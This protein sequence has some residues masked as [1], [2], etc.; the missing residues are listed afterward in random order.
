MTI[1]IS[2]FFHLQPKEKKYGTRHSKT[3]LLKR[4]R[5]FLLGGKR[6]CSI[7]GV[8]NKARYSAKGT[9][10]IFKTGPIRFPVFVDL[11]IWL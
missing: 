3:P 1:A 5:G 7:M 9:V 2:V 11:V 8:L 4:D 6:N 10:R